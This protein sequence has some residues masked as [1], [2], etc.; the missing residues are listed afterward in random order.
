MH[1][2]HLRR[3]GGY[4]LQELLVVACIVALLSAEV[5]RIYTVHLEKARESTDL[6]EV[7]AVYLNMLYGAEQA[8][9][10]FEYNGIPIVWEENSYYRAEIPLRQK[11]AAWA[12]DVRELAV[13]G[14]SVDSPSWVGM[15]EANGKCVVSY[16]PESNRVT[17]DW[18]GNNLFTA[19]G[20]RRQDID[21]MHAISAAMLDAMEEETLVIS[22]RYAEVVVFQDGAVA[23]FQD[24]GPTGRADTLSLREALVTAGL[25][26]KNIPVHSTKANWKYGYIVHVDCYG[27]VR[28]MALTPEDNNKTHTI[29]STWYLKPDLADPDL[30]GE[31]G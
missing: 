20:R 31:S 25:D 19:E 3:R 26:S 12:L 22:A 4:T 14:V 2:H 5:F 9:E 21:N 24:G 23:L 6:S 27:G 7:H 28:Y 17:L 30:V 1:I 29:F 10:S 15:P 11:R 18:G 8:G 16:V 13:A